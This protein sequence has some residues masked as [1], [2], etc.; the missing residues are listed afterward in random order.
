MQG[1]CVKC[2]GENRNLNP[3][4]DSRF[5]RMCFICQMEAVDKEG[6]ASK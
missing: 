4:E 2:N 3:Y 5:Y 1:T 6:E